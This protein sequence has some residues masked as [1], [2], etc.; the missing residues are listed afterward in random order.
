[1]TTSGRVNPKKSLNQSAEREGEAIQ[2]AIGK[3]KTNAAVGRLE[4]DT[5]SREVIR[6]AIGERRRRKLPKSRR[7]NARSPRERVRENN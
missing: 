3:W 6:T 7:K 5:M 2:R 4:S 1:M